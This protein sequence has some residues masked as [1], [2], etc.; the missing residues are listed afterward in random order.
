MNESSIIPLSIIT[1]F[2]IIAVIFYKLRNTDVKKEMKN[3]LI[4][5]KTL[6][7][8]GI[9]WVPVGVVLK[10]WG[11]IGLGFVFLFTGIVNRK[12]WN[13]DD[14]MHNE[15][16]KKVKMIISIII[17]LIMLMVVFIYFKYLSSRLLNKEEI[18]LLKIILENK[19]V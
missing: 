5:Y 4:D 17:G 8:F 9:I 2:L 1:V 6:F 11:L 18:S 12:K 13:I 7:F 16:S 3:T 19:F 10:N 15:K 14:E